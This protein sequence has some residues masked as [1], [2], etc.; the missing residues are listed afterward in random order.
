MAKGRHWPPMLTLTS[1]VFFFSVNPLLQ[2]MS[3]Q[4]NC[5]RENCGFFDLKS[6][7]FLLPSTLIRDLD[8]KSPLSLAIDL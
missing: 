5:P 1:L 7:T 6:V 3:R 4:E 2:P 8:L